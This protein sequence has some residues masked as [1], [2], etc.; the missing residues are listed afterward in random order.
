MKA[1][2]Q[3]II[4]SETMLCSELFHSGRFRVP[5]H[6]RYYDWDR[7][8]VRDLLNDI[9]GAMEE[10]REC[11]FLGAVMLVDVEEGL[12]EIND[13]QQR[14]ITLSIICAVL[15]RHFADKSPGS[16]YE[17][18]ALQVLF[19]LSRSGVWTLRN[20]NRYTQRITPAKNDQAQFRLVICGDTIGTNGKFTAACQEVTSFFSG[21]STESCKKYLSYVLQRLEIARLWV[22][23]NIDSNAVFE[24]LN[25]RGKT[26]GDFDLIRNHLY[27]Y[28]SSGTEEERRKMIHEQLEEIRLNLPKPEKAPQD[29]MRCQL[30]CRFG[31][32]HKKHFYREA[33]QAIR[34]QSD[35]EHSGQ[36]SQTD[37]AFA[38]IQQV[39]SRKHI[40]IFQ[41][42]TAHSP[43]PDLIVRPFEVASGTT[44]S[45]RNISSYLRELREYKV[46]QTLSFALLTWFLREQNE[47]SRRSA[48][49]TINKNLRRLTAFVLRT[50]FV[51]PKFEPSR[52]EKHFAD[53]SKT[54]MTADDLP[55]RRFLQFLQACDRDVG[56]L[57]D[58]RFHKLMSETR[59]TGKAK[60]RL[61]L[62]GINA[63]LQPDFQVLSQK[64][65]TIEHIL[66]ESSQHWE[67]WDGFAKTKK[68]DWVNRI[69]NL[70][71]MGPNDNRP[72]PKFNGDF[73]K[74]EKVYRDSGFAITRDLA[75][76]SDWNPKNIEQRQ[77]EMAK[78]A[79][80]VWKFA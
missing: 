24:T 13:G 33:R 58:S 52:L 40:G 50:A 77:R 43:D 31:F 72:G 55:D 32:L 15:C 34:A 7:D 48:A 9:Y 20:A 54:I 44:N 49:K 45:K 61:F 19:D 64:E 67:N 56:V 42:L 10:D 2:P 39:T 71:L 53:F 41:T 80:K 11:Y 35:E 4:K 75:R 79:V 6:Q 18:L 70:T 65:S 78:I 47:H 57:D 29:Y 3:T 30:Q 63:E 16:Q 27:S 12:W 28:F 21:M 38:L 26:L 23:A 37:Y 74:K 36:Q 25:Y 22:P 59:M 66:P 76:F 1:K 8:H 68:G 5:W 60:I 73:K 51:A 69:G 17:G 14:M 62:F 46:A